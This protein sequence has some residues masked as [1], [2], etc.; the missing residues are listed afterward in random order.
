MAI[1]YSAKKERLMNKIGHGRKSTSN[2]LGRENPMSCHVAWCFLIPNSQT[3]IIIVAGMNIEIIVIIRLLNIGRSVSDK[4]LIAV[5]TIRIP[6][7]TNI[8][9]RNPSLEFQGTEMRLLD[10]NSS[11]TGLCTIKSNKLGIVL[12]LLLDESGCWLI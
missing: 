12:P 9:P 1:V 4:K 11:K 7:A 5:R 10:R 2:A 8:V 3:E 6:N